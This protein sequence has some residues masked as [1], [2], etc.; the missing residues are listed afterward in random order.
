MADAVAADGIHGALASVTYADHFDPATGEW[1]TVTVDTRPLEIVG[2]FFGAQMAGFDVNGQLG[3]IDHLQDGELGQPY[4][5][6]TVVIAGPTAFDATTTGALPGGMSL[7]PVSGVLSGTPTESGLFTFEVSAA[8][9][10]HVVV[11]KTYTLAIADNG[12]LPPSSKIVTNPSPIIGGSTSGSGTFANGA[13]VTVTAM[14]NAG[15]HFVNWTENGAQVSASASYA[16][17]A[18]GDRTLVANFAAVVQ[19]FSVS[20]SAAPANLGS[21]S[22]NGAFANGA[23]VTVTATPNANATF[24]SWTEG[25]NVVSNSASYTF[26]IAGD[27]TLVANF[28]AVVPNF[29]V[30]TT[31]SPANL[32]ST[33]GDGSFADGASVTVVAT[34]NAGATFASWTEGGNVVSNSASYTFTASANRALVANFLSTFTI[35][36]SSAP[37]AGGSTSGGGSV[38]GGSSTTVSATANPGYTFVSWTEG[39]AQVST[40]PSYTFTAA[41]NRALVANFQTATVVVTAGT[42]NG[43]VANPAA[44]TAETSGLITVTTTAGS[45][46]FTA[47]LLLGGNKFAF[48][49]ALDATGQATVKV[50]KS[51]TVALQLDAAGFISGTVTEATN[52][53][54]F[55]ARR[56]PYSAANPLTDWPGSYTHLIG[57]PRK[58]LPPLPVGTGTHTIGTT[59]AVRVIGKLSD[60]TSYTCASFVTEAGSFPLYSDTAFKKQSGFIVSDVALNAA[61]VGSI[62]AGSPL[63]W[64][65]ATPQALGR[66][67][68]FMSHYTRPPQGTAALKVDA[69]V[70]NLDI[71]AT[72]AI[73]GMTGSWQMKLSANNVATDLGGGTGPISLQF[74]VK[75]G[76]V[77]GQLGKGA[78]AQAFTGVVWQDLNSGFA[79]LPGFSDAATLTLV[80]VYTGP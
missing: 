65:P 48:K 35:T 36:T 10:N 27:R 20:T 52:T 24:V 41:G 63:T 28:V 54:A 47:T 42:F 49:G 14:P 21:T 59:G 72:N 22:G 61:D 33:S 26:T 4:V 70:H 76:I 62:T 53:T 11:K 23:S 5:D 68:F 3:L 79:L 64:K 13:N 77:R 30:T 25:G 43:L 17:T 78:A 50:R 37:A 31:A 16:F 74:T 12:A 6:R 58:A 67:T 57:F 15:Y 46:N 2:E 69:V 19:N 80:P 66:F 29:S 75:N 45:G 38:N 40:S 51:L 44:P 60:G 9:L 32:G 55:T 8:D 71:L 34:P 7:D 1:V 18:A 56:C 73:G 39:G